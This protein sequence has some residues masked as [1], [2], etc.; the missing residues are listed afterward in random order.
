MLQPGLIQDSTS[1]FLALVLHVKKQDGTWC[2]CTDYRSLNAMTVKDKFLI[3]VVE[4]LLDEFYGANFF[5]KLDLHSGYHRVHV[6]LKMCTLFI[7]HHGYFNF[8]VMPFSLS[9]APLAF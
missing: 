4:E 9:N 1:S 5:T 8:L 6:A 3:P 2:F 7:T